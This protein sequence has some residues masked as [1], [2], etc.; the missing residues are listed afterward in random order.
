[1]FVV[2]NL[3]ISVRVK[4]LR[5]IPDS[6]QPYPLDIMAD[7][8]GFVAP[9]SVADWTQ[10]MAFVEQLGDDLEKTKDESMPTKHL[11]ASKDRA[12]M[13]LF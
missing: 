5:S 3:L 8:S 13:V 10:L 2:A 4:S 12:A 11:L 9:P 6:L 7:P 1:V